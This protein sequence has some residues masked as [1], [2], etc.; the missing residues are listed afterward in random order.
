LDNLRIAPWELFTPFPVQP[1]LAALLALHRQ[2]SG[3]VVTPSFTPEDAS[4]RLPKIVGVRW[5]AD[6][7]DDDI[8]L[9]HRSGDGDGPEF[10]LLDLGLHAVP[11][12]SIP[13]V[14]R[15]GHTSTIALHHLG[16]VASGTGSVLSRRC[17]HRVTLDP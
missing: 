14:R 4:S 2:D 10:C 12:P 8:L 7:S 15:T 1:N 13:M 5:I 6:E 11:S 9:E 3:P 16:Q 17:A